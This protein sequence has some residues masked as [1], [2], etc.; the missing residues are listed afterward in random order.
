MDKIFD[1]GLGEVHVVLEIVE[2]HFGFDHPEFCEVPGR[3]GVLGPEGRA[4]G[5][6]VGECHGAQFPFEL[7][8]DGEVGGAAEEI[9][10]EID[11]AVFMAGWVVK[12]EGAYAERF[13]G[14]FCIGSGDNR[15]V[16][17]DKSFLVEKLVNGKGQRVADAEDSAEGLGPESQ[18]GDLP[19][20][21]EAGFVL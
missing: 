11:R 21:F 12:R 9:L 14:A 13:T 6:N 15:R 1:E 17:V 7:A 8:A 2:G 3:I 10:A 20:V 5:V 19:E 4:E 16:E 18:M